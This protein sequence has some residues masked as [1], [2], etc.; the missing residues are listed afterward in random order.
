MKRL[1]RFFNLLVSGAILLVSPVLA[2]QTDFNFDHLTVE[3]GLSQST[4]FSIT[5]DAEGFMWFATRDGLNKFDSR[6]VVVYKSNPQ[7]KNSIR[8]NTVYSLYSDSQGQLWVG[9]R[10]GLSAYHP[11]S[12]NFTT[13]L[14]DPKNDS[15]LSN[16]TVTCIF[17]DRNKNLWIGTRQGLNL[18]VSKDSISFIRFLH[19]DKENNSLMDDDV[20]SV[21]QDKDG[22]I[23]VGTSSG[24]SRL[25][26][27][28]PGDYQFTSYK[29][30]DP[31]QHGKSNWI[32]AIIEDDQDRL[33]IGTEK[34][35]LKI[36][37]KKESAFQTV[38]WSKGHELESKT[39]RAI[40]KDNDRL[41]VG[42]IGGAFIVSQNQYEIQKLK[43][44]PDNVTSVS[45]NSIRSLYKDKGGSYWVGTF[46]GGVNFYN[47]LSKQFQLLKPGKSH[48]KN[49]FK[50][51]SAITKD[52][53]QRLWIGTEGSGLLAI[54]EKTDKTIH[55]F[56]HDEQNKNSLCHDR[57]KCLLPDEE[58]LWIGTIEGLD[59]YHFA[60]GKFQHYHKQHD[61]KNALPDDT[62]YD[63]IKDS[64]GDLWI[65]TYRGGIIRFDRKKGIVETFT[66]QPDDIK[67][68]SSSGA[69]RLFID[70]N[71]N[72][73]I[74]TING[75]N[76]K[77]SGGFIR[78]L[79]NK[80]TDNN[81]TSISGD[82]ILCIF[83]DTQKRLWIGTRGNG[84]N[85]MRV[86]DGTFEKFTIADGLS[87][88]TI[89]GI[90]E[91]ARGALWI[92]TENG[93]SRFD[94]DKGIAKNYDRSDGLACKEFNFN[95]YYKDK[96]GR[97]YF[98]GYNG[99]VLFYP[100]SV[101]ENNAIPKLAFT[102]LKLFNKEVGVMGDDEIL[103]Q[104]IGF[105]QEIQF[106]YDQN[107][108][109][110]EFAV[111]NYTNAKKNQF[112][113]K[114]E[115]FEEQW[116]FSKEPVATYMNLSP[117]HY[118]LLI[119]GTNND[120][121]W[122]DVPLA[123]KIVVLPPPW[124]TWWAYTVY[125]SVFLAL[126]YAWTRFNRKQVKLEHDL[127][128][129]QL[130]MKR[131]EELHQT[132]LNFFANIAHEIRT[133]LTLIAGPV[134]QLLEKKNQDALV[135]KELT[136]VKSNT[137]RLL[138]LMNQLLDFNRQET[139]NIKLKV[140]AG[141]IVS[142][143]REILLTFQEYAQSRRVSVEFH[144]YE[145]YIPLWYDSEELAKVFCNLLVNAFKFTPGGGMVSIR[146]NKE[147]KEDQYFNVR[148]TIEDNGLGISPVHLEK[149]F[150]RFYQ[151][152]HSGLHEAGFGI[153]LALTKGIIDLHHGIIEVESSEARN[154]ANGFTKFTISL[155]G[156]NNHFDKSQISGEEETRNREEKWSEADVLPPQISD[157]HSWKGKASG[158]LIL[159]V[160]DNEQIRK[161]IRDL[162]RAYHYEILECASGLEGW[163]AATDKLPDLILSDVVMPAMSGLELV[164]KLKNDQ[165][166]SH[167]PVILLTGRSAINYQ[168]EGLGTGADDYLT[169]PFNASL[170]LL[171]I[172]NLLAMREKLKEKYSRLVILQPRQEVV[173]NPDD[174]FLARLMHA[175]EANLGDTD[176]NVSRLVREIGMSR[177]VLFRKTKMLTG[178]SVIDLIRSV[179]LKRAEMLLKQG[180]MSIS[181]VAFTVGFS[182][183]KYFSKSFREQ[184]GK[185]PSQY[186]V[187]WTMSNEAQL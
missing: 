184:Y 58:G 175:M 166:T 126:L 132:K 87:G 64:N 67:S 162:L 118:T 128:L 83:E 21:F 45:D 57:I 74:G 173:E 158:K 31:D 104:S 82:Y 121:V 29:I 106:R 111:L 19:Q 94:P 48:S 177:P 55:Y 167:I 15:T 120:G 133:P 96:T 153:G 145:E 68:L 109:A 49:Y 134:E 140:E 185:S 172:Q 151:A 59:Y 27:K 171:K 180:K 56:K 66:N 97:M 156:G 154:S 37:N 38:P 152:E 76:K 43:N 9:T 183:P 174:K 7:D 22:M 129:E 138:R 60:S 50:I 10:E 33:W 160:E 165:R 18:L 51:A 25:D 168:V 84:L 44:I 53:L 14:S 42:T 80:G 146:I 95:S 35:G 81:N 155:P 23:W 147:E 100:D 85:R 179:R 119:K 176:F 143:I 135:K 54:D 148:I 28:S 125:A 131:Q 13:F 24:L 163:E 169:K 39:I 91:D 62:I 149:I 142:F 112:A 32:N 88:N 30:P 164:N 113:Y 161:Y 101:R 12:D 114:L 16:S 36:F 41:W 26:F 102:S 89:Y 159:L 11:Q 5:Q 65:A 141:N 181:E 8:D 136:I 116:N 75:L 6:K 69:T 127:H 144:A 98:G 63:L 137:D 34:S 124:K 70:S 3:E 4:V 2:Q 79:L 103:K 178:L 150:H 130:E 90:Q 105:C 1:I 110:V 117:G 17:E 107:V 71:H 78:Y 20:R 115:G 186:A 73:W 61:A 123:M 108:F 86:A 52:H 182:D 40:L 72:L 99:V 93:L 170:L 47:P 187:E 157:E 122:N 77:T 46:H 139:G 92:S